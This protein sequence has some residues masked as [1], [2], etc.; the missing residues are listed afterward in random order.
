[1][2]YLI[3][4]VFLLR[5][6]RMKKT[7]RR[8]RLTPN[9]AEPIRIPALRPGGGVPSLGVV[10][11]SALDVVSLE[12][13]VVEVVLLLCVLADVVLLLLLLSALTTLVPT[14]MAPS[15][16]SRLYAAL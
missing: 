14:F 3:V 9:E 6:F 1:M 7:I 5:R 16:P 13:V 10:A 2:G 11:L 4:H 8:T 12:S 15:H